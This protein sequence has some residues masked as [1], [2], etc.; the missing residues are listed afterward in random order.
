MNFR[1]ILIFALITFHLE[2]KYS[3]NFNSYFYKNFEF[4]TIILNRGL[5]NFNRL[6]KQFN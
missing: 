1:V 6:S 2:L 4:L 5:I 3:T